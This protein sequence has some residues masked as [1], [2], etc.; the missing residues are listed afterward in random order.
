[1]TRVGK[2]FLFVNLALSLVF[3]TWGFGIYSNYINWT[4]KKIGDREGEFTKRADAIK[5]VMEA[6]G[7]AETSWNSFLNPPQGLLAVEASRPKLQA[8]YNELLEN[9]RAGPVQALVYENGALVKKY[10]YPVLGPVLNTAKQPVQGLKSLQ[11]LDGDYRQKQKAIQDVTDAIE[12]QVELEKQLTEEIG[13][14]QEKGLRADLA[15]VQLAEKRSLDE[16]EFLKPLLYNR[17]VEVQLLQRRQQALE[18]RVKEL[19]SVKVAKQ[20]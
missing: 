18:A 10:G 14:G 13:D 16:Q 1:M 9:L 19:E 4:D 20:P 11:A 15:A 7:R 12:K 5:R 2:I 6:R 8:R 3:A 17:Q